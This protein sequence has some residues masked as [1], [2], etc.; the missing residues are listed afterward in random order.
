[1]GA[2]ALSTV[3]L[4]GLGV[5][6]RNLALNIADRGFR[7]IGWDAD[8][9]A[10]ANFAAGAVATDLAELV[11]DLEPPRA[12]LLMV[13]AGEPVERVI[14][15]LRPHLA[16]G[17]LIADGGNSHYRDSRRRADALR[18]AGLL[19]LGLG[20]SGGEAGARHGPAIMAGGDRAAYARLEALLEAIA[21]PAGGEACVA[22]LGP[23]GAG[24]FVKTVHNGIEY[25]VMQ[26]I[27]EA[28]YLLRHLGGLT[29]PEMAGLFRNWNRG[30]LESYL[31]DC[32]AAVL[33]ARDAG[34]GPLLDMI[35]DRA[36]EKG[37][38]RWAA[39]EALELGVAAPSLAEAV[40][41]RAMTAAPRG[42]AAEPSSPPLDGLPADLEPALLAAAVC[43]YGQGFAL[44]AAAGREYGWELPLARIAR[45]LQGGCIIRARLLDGFAAAFDADATPGPL[46]HP[47][48]AAQVGAGL[49]PWR[50]L[51]AAGIAA[52]L[53]LPLFASTLA[54]YDATTRPR[55]WA[56]MIQGMRD[57]FGRHGFERIDRPGQHH[58]DWGEA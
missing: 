30:V 14:D 57:R 5:M 36:G 58:H 31:V 54:W 32:A 27:A 45:L 53:P 23:D 50:R 35:R 15:A 4:I 9:A 48:L 41:A 21:A 11:R 16:A 28:V 20:I 7:V 18:Q 52:G 3:G 51:L 47:A 6:G 22:W 37:T 46:A 49:V 44:L 19:Y 38:G 10:C 17:D 8:P 2:G 43:C 56:D 39:V 34:G 40:A 25:A 24:H 26:L 55:L 29:P 13:P 12:L 1:L 33:A 42:N